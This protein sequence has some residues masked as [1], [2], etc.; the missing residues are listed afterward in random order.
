VVTPVTPRIG[1]IG[2]LHWWNQCF[3]ADVPFIPSWREV[4][5]FRNLLFQ[6]RPPKNFT[7]QPSTFIQ[8][9]PCKKISI[10]FVGIP[11][12]FMPSDVHLALPGTWH[13]KMWPRKSL[14]FIQ[15]D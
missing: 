12:S 13:R 2:K 6:C 4:L 1:S 7:N 10:Q 8:G 9:W 11:L 15:I 3:P 5:Q 14:D